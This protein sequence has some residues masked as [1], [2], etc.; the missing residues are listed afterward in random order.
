[1]DIFG[2]RK[3]IFLFYYKSYKIKYINTN[4]DKQI[5]DLERHTIQNNLY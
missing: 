3:D 1:M 4:M 5:F 2:N